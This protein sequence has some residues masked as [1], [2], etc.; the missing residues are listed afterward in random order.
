MVFECEGSRAIS[1][2]R[3]PTSLMVGPHTHV[4]ETP[5][6]SN[7]PDPANEPRFG[8]WPTLQIPDK[9]FGAGESEVVLERRPR[10]IWR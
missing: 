4:G 5:A 1:R 2:A 9:H 8:D 3:N 10:S 6:R 7:S